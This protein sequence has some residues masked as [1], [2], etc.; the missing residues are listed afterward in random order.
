MLLGATQLAEALLATRCTN[1]TCEC[2]MDEPAWNSYYQRQ[3]LEML[4]LDVLRKMPAEQ[5]LRER[6]A[7]AL[8]RETMP[9]IILRMSKLHE[10]AWKEPVPSRSNMPRMRL[11][12]P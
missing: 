10:P 2:N 11:D 1:P 5:Y 3:H 8:S 4:R 12:R 7:G 6:T 9:Q